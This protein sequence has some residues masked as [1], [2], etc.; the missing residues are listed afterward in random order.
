MATVCLFRRS[1]PLISPLHH[2]PC[3][4]R[5]RNTKQY[6]GFLQTSTPPINDQ[7]K[8]PSFAFAFEYYCPSPIKSV[9]I[10]I[11]HQHRWRPPPLFQTPPPCPPGPYLP[12]IPPYP[13]HPPH[14]WRRQK[15]T[16]PHQGAV[17]ATRGPARRAPTRPVAHTLCRIDERSQA[18]LVR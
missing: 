6:Q 18:A 9:L 10:L 13:F 16:S 8:P 12:P 5:R 17:S 1:A 14:E 7:P 11:D 15:R 3:L 4:L 2:S